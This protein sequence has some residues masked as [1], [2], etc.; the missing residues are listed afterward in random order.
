MTPAVETVAAA[1]LQARR[2][3]R[4]ADTAQLAPLLQTPAEAYEVQDRVAAQLGWFA[5]GVPRC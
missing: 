5:P 1:L 3:R 4:P 2:D